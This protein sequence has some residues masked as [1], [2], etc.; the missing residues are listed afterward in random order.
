MINNIN[1]KAP[2]KKIVLQ[3][4]MENGLSTRTVSGI[5]IVASSCNYKDVYIKI[6][7]I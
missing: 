6:R 7:R 5:P 3:N 4:K 1:K 2:N